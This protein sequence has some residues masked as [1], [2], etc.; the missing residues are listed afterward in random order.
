M[1][2]GEQDYKV[3]REDNIMDKDQ[4]DSFFGGCDDKNGGVNCNDMYSGGF[5][6]IR[7]LTGGKLIVLVL[8]LIIA[9][10]IVGSAV[11]MGSTGRFLAGLIFFGGIGFYLYNKSALEKHQPAVNYVAVPQGPAY[12]PRNENPLNDNTSG[13]NY[14]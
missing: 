4:L 11:G 10:Q 13:G 5:D 2:L 7:W 1:N 14:W 9:V 3:S 8:F 12:P 6:G